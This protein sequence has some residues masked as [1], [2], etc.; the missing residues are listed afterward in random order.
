MV[1]TNNLFLKTPF[2]YSPPVKISNIS[3][4][5]IGRIPDLDLPQ[6]RAE[7]IKVLHPLQKKIAED[8]LTSLLKKPLSLFSFVTAEQPHGSE[9]AI[10]SP[11]L[12]LEK[13]IEKAD[14][15][16]T[17]HEGIMLA[18]DVGDCAPVWILEREGKIGALVHSGKKGTL[19]GIVPKTI[20]RLKSEFSIKPTDLI[21]IIGPCI[22]PPCYEINFAKMIHQ[23][24]IDTGVTKIY[25]DQ[26]CTACHLDRFYSYR[27]EKGH[28]GRMLAILYL[29]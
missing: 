27:R 16:I 29:S 21:M 3:A 5:L 4:F 11:P 1:T 23:Q 12:P 14:A 13:R 22:R 8:H 20:L 24:A 28:T 15:L 7:M 19:A 26:I 2:L 17:Q 9:I 10:I 18:I 25:D 6:E